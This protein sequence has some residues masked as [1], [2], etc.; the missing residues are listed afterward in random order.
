MASL[1]VDQGTGALMLGCETIC[2]CLLVS[3]INGAKYRGFKGL[4]GPGLYR[5]SC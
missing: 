1:N 3:R 5:D 4:I 2:G